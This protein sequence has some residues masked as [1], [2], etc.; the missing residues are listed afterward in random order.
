[1]KG[2]TRWL[3][4]MKEARPAFE[5]KMDLC[6]VGIPLPWRQ[7]RPAVQM[8]PQ[9]NVS[10]VKQADIC[11]Y[12]KIICHLL[13]FAFF[14]SR[15]RLTGKKRVDAEYGACHLRSSLPTSPKVAFLGN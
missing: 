4:L 12:C 14:P 9:L 13:F 10:A 2:K 8:Y 6:P 15:V 3:L 5:I 1:M 7:S 11:V